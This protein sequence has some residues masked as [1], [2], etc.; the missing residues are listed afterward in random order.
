MNRAQSK[1]PKQGSLQP[2]VVGMPWEVLS[3]DITGP[4]PKSNKGSVYILTAM[5]S[6]SKFAF[7]FPIRNQEAVTIAKVLVDQVFAY[8]GTPM[9]ILSDQGKNFESQLFKELC[10]CM[11]IEKVRTSSYQPRTNGQQEKFHRTLNAMIAKVVKESQK[12][13]DEC[14]PQL[15]AAYRS[16]VHSSTGCSPN[17]LLFGRENRAPVDLVLQ[18]PETMP[19]EDWSINDFVARKQEVML[20]AYKSARNSLEVAA[21]RRKK[22]YDYGVKTVEFQPQ[23]KVWYYYPRRYLKR[24][25]KFQFMYVGPYTV[26]K[27]LGAVNYLIKNNDRTPAIVVHADKLKAYQQPLNLEVHRVMN[28]R[29][30]CVVFVDPEI[31]NGVEHNNVLCVSEI[32]A[33]ENEHAKLPRQKKGKAKQADQVKE[34][35]QQPKQSYD[36]ATCTLTIKGYRAARQHRRRCLK[37]KNTEMLPCPEPLLMINQVWRVAGDDIQGPMVFAPEAVGAEADCLGDLVLV[38]VVPEEAMGLLVMEEGT[39][40]Q[41]E[42]SPEYGVV[43]ECGERWQK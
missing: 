43:W 32:Q 34:R 39:P 23:Q 38:G 7:A 1:P 13:W 20:Q 29:I 19:A 17:F 15:L 6:F 5:D 21:S 22:T 31:M 25:K 2:M 42:C 24:S 12:D 28:I 18:N 37:R 41:D 9:R 8:F 33:M 3:I 11:D 10:R 40:V 4:H 30:P 27:K 35:V 26:M 16:S 14:L 36:C